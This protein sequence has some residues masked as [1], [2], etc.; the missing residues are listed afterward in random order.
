MRQCVAASVGTF[1]A[2]VWTGHLPDMQ[3]GLQQEGLND[4]QNGKMTAG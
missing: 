2:L 1:F 3:E 4:Q